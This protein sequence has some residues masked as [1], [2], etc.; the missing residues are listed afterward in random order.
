MVLLD[1]NALLWLSVGDPRLGRV[2]LAALDQA[3][4]EGELAVSAI[5]F[6]EVAMLKDK[7]RIDFPEDVD[8]WRLELLSRN[9]VEIPV[10]G[11]LAARAGRL[12]GIDGDPADRLVIATALEGHQLVT[13]DR[14]I[15]NWPGALDRLDAR[16]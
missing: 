2:A 12:A 8:L 16:R 3:L 10:D 11:A 4:L 1:T 13:S 6:W 5:T 7:G 9:V 14:D 15:L